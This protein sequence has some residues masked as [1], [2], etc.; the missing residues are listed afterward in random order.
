MRKSFWLIAVIAL[1]VGACST[2][3]CS[4]NTRV[5]TTYKLMGDVKTLA[6]P[7]TVT[8]DLGDGNDSVILNKLVSTDSFQLPMSYN[9]HED[10]FYFK[11]EGATGTLLDTVIVSKKDKPHFEAVDCN[12]IIFH[13]ITDVRYTKY[14]IDSIGV[15]NK[16]VTNEISKS[17]FHL[18]LKSNIH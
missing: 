15:N 6:D 4:L 7:L 3:D 8:A 17:N 2:I 5:A 11:S 10:V 12:P 16:Q 14:F 1:F 13:E 9:R 18:Y